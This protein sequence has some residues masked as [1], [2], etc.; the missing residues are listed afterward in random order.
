MRNVLTIFHYEYKMLV[1]RRSGWGAFLAAMLLSML[2]TFPSGG[3]LH[4]LE[5]LDDPV[6][7]VSRTMSLGG[8]P[9]A[10]GLMILLS[11][12]FSIDKNTGVKALV[13][14]GATA[15]AQYIF[16]KSLGAICYTF[17]LFSLFLACN[18]GIYALAAPFHV[19]VSKLS[20]A[21]GKT[22]FVCALPVCAFVSLLSLCLPALMDVRLFYAAAAVLF[23]VNASVTGSAEPMPFYCITSGDLIKLIWQH[24]AWLCPDA[25]NAKANLAF[26]VGSGMLSMAF[27][28]VKKGFW[29]EDGG[30]L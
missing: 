29:R 21:T 22:A 11:D 27:L 13:M 8:L 23:V 6:Y 20:A 17:T 24:P 1:T 16:G 15:K 19:S 7:F 30:R 14:A 18:A 2:D 10:F 25:G 3:N 28:F 5:F 26:L 9:L 12:R 4:R